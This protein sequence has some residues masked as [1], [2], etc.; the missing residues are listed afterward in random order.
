MSLREQTH[1][2]WTVRATQTQYTDMPIV[3]AT[4]N[5]N[6]RDIC[7]CCDPDTRAELVSSSQS[8]E[9]TVA[10][11]DKDAINPRPDTLPVAINSLQ[12]VCRF[13]DCIQSHTLIGRKSTRACAVRQV[14]NIFVSGTRACV[15][16]VENG[17]SFVGCDLSCKSC[18]SDLKMQRRRRTSP[19]SDCDSESLDSD[20]GG[21]G[22]MASPPT[23]CLL[24]TSPSPRDR[25]RSRMP[26][27]A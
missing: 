14:N 1:T 22:G 21:E 5:P 9:V 27:S 23:V 19:A 8:T 24:Y 3:Q 20:A 25:T 17:P 6:R 18:R 12:P 16:V 2:V 10:E 11:T 4:D 13:P 15:I 26:S 7:P